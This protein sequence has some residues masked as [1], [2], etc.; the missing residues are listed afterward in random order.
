ML[1]QRQNPI[2]LVLFPQELWVAI[3]HILI[4]DEKIEEAIFLSRVCKAIHDAY[5]KLN[6]NPIEFLEMFENNINDP[7]YLFKYVKFAKSINLFS[8]YKDVVGEGN[9]A[10]SLTR[11]IKELNLE[12]LDKSLKAIEES[13]NLQ[14]IAALKKAGEIA[15]ANSSSDEEDEDTISNGQLFK[16]FESNSFNKTVLCLHLT[17]LACSFE[18]TD[19]W[20]NEFFALRATGITHQQSEFYINLMGVNFEG[21]HF[22]RSL[23][24]ANLAY[25]NLKH[26]TWSANANLAHTN[27]EYADFSNAN[28]V[29]CTFTNANASN[30]I[31]DKVQF[32]IMCGVTV[33]GNFSKARFLNCNGFFESISC[34]FT[35]TKFAHVN[36]FTLNET[37]RFIGN[38]CNN[39]QFENF[40]AE[41]LELSQ[42]KFTGATFVN[43][44]IIEP[45]K[46]ESLHTRVNT[47]PPTV[48]NVTADKA[49]IIQSNFLSENIKN[50][51]Q[52]LTIATLELLLKDRL[53]RL[54]EYYEQYILKNNLE[55]SSK[56]N[57]KF[58]FSA[59]GN[60]GAKR[61]TTHSVDF[62]SSKQ[63]VILELLNQV[64]LSQNYNKGNLSTKQFN[65][66][67][68]EMFT[69]LTNAANAS[70][71]EMHNKGSNLNPHSY[72]TYL[73]E[74]ATELQNDRDQ[75]NA[76]I[77]A[78][79]ESCINIQVFLKSK[80]EKTPL[81]ELYVKEREASPPSK[82]SGIKN[83]FNIFSHIN[84]SI[85]KKYVELENKINIV[86]ENK[87]QQSAKLETSKK[88]KIDN[89]EPRPNRWL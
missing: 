22:Q 12:V 60:S 52:I 44:K 28:F 5:Q 41:N 54:E 64:I 50:V 4:R 47:V 2:E 57:P 9:L 38:T 24:G 76:K 8:E 61:A 81:T 73:M 75:I 80:T 82:L 23:K 29:R 18:A 51:S 20:Y 30:A 6:I 25:A 46:I 85:Q 39:T 56:L 88:K 27:L 33:N 45:P 78:E 79:P 36:I 1:T 67:L 13:N 58:I 31:F 87:A 26:S 19:A 32:D 89:F 43:T 77:K 7:E 35:Q 21:A 86:K 3:F 83:G 62:I 84:S 59:H 71:V 14:D 55:E 74:Y 34:N 16:K 11:P 65:E 69:Q 70:V 15:E 68:A 10:Y 63:E 48:E 17:I 42:T 66:L 53:K 40:Y 72:T 37:K 49:S